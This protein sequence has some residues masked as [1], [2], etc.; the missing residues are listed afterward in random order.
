MALSS[1]TTRIVMKMHSYFRHK[2]LYGT[3]NEYKEYLPKACKAKNM[4]IED[5]N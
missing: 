3:D 1:E 4:T 5:L 2:L